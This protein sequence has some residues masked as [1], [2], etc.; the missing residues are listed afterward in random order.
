VFFLSGGLGFVWCVWWYFLYYSAAQH[1]KLSAAER[2][3][4]TE[5]VA[6]KA[7]E[8][9]ADEAAQ[10]IPWLQLFSYRAVWALMLCKFL[11]DA[12]WYF[13]ANWLPKYLIDARGYNIAGMAGFAWMPWAGAG[14]GCLV[15]GYFSSWLIMRGHS[16]NASRKIA[17]GVS[18]AV[19]PVLF[20]V[21]FIE[22]NAWVIV[23][24]IIG[25]F[26]QQAWSTLVMTLPTD[27]FPRKA[28]GSVAGLVG[29]GG[30]MGGIVF[31]KLGGFWLEAHPMATSTSG[32]RWG[33]IFF[34]AGILH[35]VSFLV[36]VIMIPRIRMIQVKRT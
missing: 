9:D 22:S 4:L 27:L 2:S 1:P 8:A 13:I 5:V 23:P 19:M 10:N 32:E 33:P 24:F 28:I 18:V 3:E 12:V 25:Y 14:V 35:I 36:I 26:G 20:L 34:F 7:A 29:F 16:I 6:A 31:N 11:G 15:V 21:P 30:A 17:L